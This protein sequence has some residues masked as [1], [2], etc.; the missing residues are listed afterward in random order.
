[1][2]ELNDVMGEMRSLMYDLNEDLPKVTQNKAAA[3]RARKGT[4][5]LEKQTK[6]FRALS[7]AHHKK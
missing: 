3:A 7:V 4:L 1:M 5:A 2:S 6:R